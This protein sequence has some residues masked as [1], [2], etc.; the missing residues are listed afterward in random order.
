MFKKSD[1]ADAVETYRLKTRGTIETAGVDGLSGFSLRFR[2]CAVD[3]KRTSGNVIIMLKKEGYQDAIVPLT[4]QFNPVSIINLSSVYSWTTDFLSGG[5]WKYSPDAVYVEMDRKDM[6]KAETEQAR[7]ISQIRRFVLFNY[8][9]LK[10]GH[11]EHLASLSVLTGL[12]T[13]RLGDL[14]KNASDE[15]AAADKIVLTVV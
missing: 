11:Q 9:A 12:K 2:L 6:T 3:L 13:E 8:A 7:K 14:I 1:N 15:I 10:S 5:V 4:S